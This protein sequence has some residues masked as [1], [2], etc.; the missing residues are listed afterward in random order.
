ME[1]LTQ[2]QKHDLL[3]EMPENEM[4]KQMKRMFDIASPDS[5]HYIG[6]GT[7]EFGK[8]LVT[9]TDDPIRGTKVTAYVV[10]MG[11]ING[12]AANGLLGTINTQINQA[13][14]TPTF[15]KR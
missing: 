5:Q 7:G 11:N 6:Q 3:R 15:L 10:K 12:A 1:L 13:L 2:A 4:H 9:I 8:D 14:N